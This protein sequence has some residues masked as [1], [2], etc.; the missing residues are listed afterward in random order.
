MYACLLILGSSAHHR[1]QLGLHKVRFISLCLLSVE[2]GCEATVKLLLAH[3]RL[4]LDLP[5][6][7][8][9]SPLQVRAQT[10]VDFE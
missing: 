3:P 1:S 2:T 7:D 9:R 4:D 6:N 5:T 8:G 10:I